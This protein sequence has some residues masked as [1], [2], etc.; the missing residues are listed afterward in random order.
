MPNRADL[1]LRR[2]L[3][4]AAAR[5]MLDSGVHDY[6]FAKQKAAR[7][8]GVTASQSLPSN[9]EIDAALI[10]YR[11]IF[12]PGSQDSELPALRRQALSV[13]TRLAT[14]A[15]RLC[16]T[17]VSGA[18]SP[19]SDIELEIY[20]DSS[21]GFEHF[22]LNNHLSFKAEAKGDYIFYRLAGVPADVVVRIY[23]ER[24]AHARGSGRNGTR[25]CLSATQLERLLTAGD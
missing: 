17:L 9:D 5:V 11:A 7:Q 21:K 24:E 18:V 8:L 16:G 12:Q 15:P 13:M 20:A 2:R 3:A 22:L 25:R 1:Q 19:H 10:E 4:E 6:A 23:P 14:F